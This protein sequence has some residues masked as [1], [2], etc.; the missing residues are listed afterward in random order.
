MVLY[1]FI[2][3]SFLDSSHPMQGSL[4]L[5]HKARQEDPSRTKQ[6]IAN[7]FTNGILHSGKGDVAGA[8][9]G[10]VLSGITNFLQNQPNNEAQQS[11]YLNWIMLDEEQL[12]VVTSGTGFT[13][14]FSQ[15]GTTGGGVNTLL[16]ANNGDGID[17]TR[18]GFL[19]IYISNTNTNFPVYFDNLH[20][21]HKRG[22]LLEE[23]AYYPFG[24]TMSGI[25]SKASSFGNPA[26]KLKYNGKEE[27]K[28]EFS[29]GSGLEW[30]D[31]GA[32]E[33]DPQLGRWNTLDPLADKYRQFSPY[34]YCVNNPIRL[35]DP[36]G[37]QV[38]VTNKKD[39]IL[40]MY[41][42]NL[43]SRSQYE[44]NSKGQLVVIKGKIN[45]KGSDTYSKGLNEAITNKKTITLQ[46]GLSYKG[47]NGKTKSVDGDAGGGVTS[48]PAKDM[49]G[50]PFI[51]QRARVAGDPSVIVSGN[52]NFAL[53]GGVT[54]G[55]ELILMHEILG[56]ALPIIR[57]KMNGNA[58][59]NENKVR[60]EIKVPL[61]RP[62]PDHKESDFGN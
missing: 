18:N 54:D 48:T 46:I 34:S 15:A 49:K 7:F 27:Q 17:V 20:V 56:H 55:P 13:S 31:Y 23:N 30:L 43:V 11:A 12:K 6:L 41:L 25:S 5:S 53:P 19:Y 36:D 38:V 1:R 2:L 60:G 44:F 26:N 28:E 57:G 22:P 8:L 14:L 16:Q 61:R 45:E 39:Q 42:I 3:K 52:R 10:V 40:L 59:E 33:Q 4:G 47:E 50:S 24:L 35:I 58:V 62:E 32:R 37:K 29:D 51:D 21:V 9:P